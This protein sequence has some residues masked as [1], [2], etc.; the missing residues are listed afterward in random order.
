MHYHF[1]KSAL[2][3]S[4]YYHYYYYYSQCHA[5]ILEF[6]LTQISIYETRNGQ[7]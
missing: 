7:N 6:L 2:R 5:N 4:S 3:N 1:G